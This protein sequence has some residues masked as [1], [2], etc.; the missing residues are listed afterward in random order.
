MNIKK[1]PEIGRIAVGGIE[2][3]ACF[4]NSFNVTLNPY[5]AR[6]RLGEAKMSD[7]GGDVTYR[8][9]IVMSTPDA[10]MLAKMIMQLAQES[11]EGTLP[12]DVQRH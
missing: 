12:A 2:L 8:R 4:V 5:V 3:E 9:A 1:E 7:G 6:I 10:I 11:Q